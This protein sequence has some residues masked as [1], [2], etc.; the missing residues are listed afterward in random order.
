MLDQRRLARFAALWALTLCM[1]LAGC[2]KLKQSIEEKAMEKAGLEK[3]EGDEQGKSFTFKG[4]KPGEE[5]TFGTTQKM[6]ENFPADV[7]VYPG[8]KVMAA[9]ASGQDAF[10]VTLTTNDPVAKVVEFYNS[11]IP[12]DGD[13]MAI[14]NMLSYTT[15]KHR[16]TVMTNENEGAAADTVGKT[17]L[18]LTVGPATEPPSKS[19]AGSAKP[20]K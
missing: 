7:P 15:D 18:V 9:A 5:V 11:K 3:A 10:S 2:K 19:A 20:K 8:A 16:V 14:A 12:A 13:R 1:P 17:I 6:P 4:S